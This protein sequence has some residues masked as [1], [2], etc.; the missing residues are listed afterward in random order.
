MI[1]QMPLLPIKPV[2]YLRFVRL[3]NELPRSKIRSSNSLTDRNAASCGELTPCPAKGGVKKP[4]SPCWLSS[5]RKRCNRWRKSIAIRIIGSASPPLPA[6][7]SAPRFSFYKNHYSDSCATG[8]RRRRWLWQ[9]DPAL[10]KFPLK[11]R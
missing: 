1:K 4:F 3:L 6:C 7:A 10:R 5:S 2:K 8:F 9:N 11:W